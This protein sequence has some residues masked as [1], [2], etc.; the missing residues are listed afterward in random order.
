MDSVNTAAPH[1]A[2]TPRVTPA[3]PGRL[4][5]GFSPG[6]GTAYCFTALVTQATAKPLSAQAHATPNVAGS[7]FQGAPNT[8][9]STAYVG[10]QTTAINPDG[11][12]RPSRSLTPS[13]PEATCIQKAVES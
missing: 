12:R 1:T 10:T 13:T 9:P 11:N 5:N 2:C 4:V 3:D 7:S 6:A 8:G